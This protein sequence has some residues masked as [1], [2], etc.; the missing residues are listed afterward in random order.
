LPA[1]DTGPIL[2]Q[3]SAALLFCHAALSFVLRERMTEC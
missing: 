3:P 2:L 1:C